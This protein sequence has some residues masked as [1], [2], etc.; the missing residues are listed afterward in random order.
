MELFDF[1]NS[2]GQVSNVT[3]LLSGFTQ[4]VGVEFSPSSNLLYI[5]GYGNSDIYQYDLSSGNAATIISSQTIIA[6]PSMFRGNLQLAPDGMIY[7]NISNSSYL[8]RIENPDVVGVGAN[9]VD[10]AINFTALIR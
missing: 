4:G 1:D 9:F 6:S 3:T 7:Q 5:A 2:T 8:A 10:S